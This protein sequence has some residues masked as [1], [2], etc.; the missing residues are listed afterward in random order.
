MTEFLEYS[1]FRYALAGVVLISI[2]AAIIGSYIITR[3]MVA[4]AGGIT[5][6]CFGGLGLGY[7]LGISPVAMAA[8]FA[9]GS[10]AA[11]EWMSARMKLREDSAI[12]VVWSLGM[13][14]GVLFVF[15]TPGYV[16]ELNSFLFG[17]ILT[18]GATDLLLFA[19]FTAALCVFFAWRYRQIV[20]VAFDADFARVQR[21]PV[22]FINYAMMVFVAVC[23]VLTI[24]LVGVML[25]M[26][27][28]SLPM[29]TAEV[30]CRRFSAMVLV[31]AVIAVLAGVAGLFVG[32]AIDVPVSAVIVIILGV[33]FAIAKIIEALRR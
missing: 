14:V 20:A 8:V 25:L 7:F 6:A 16:P 11:V 9:V 3:R 15:L 21:L 31:S 33:V 17:N 1:F 27:V 18:I 10:G 13:A 26:S 5:H 4:I 32:A 2:A 23:I 30:F 29:M 28:M 22:R 24:R 19:A 12:A